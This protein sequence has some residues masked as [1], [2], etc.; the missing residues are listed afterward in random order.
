MTVFL[1]NN[2][3]VFIRPYVE[4]D[5]NKIQDLNKIEGWSNL[6]ENHMNTKEA[7]KNSNVSFVVET[8]TKNVIGYIRG[9]TDTRISLFICELLIDKMYRGFGLGKELIYYVHS[10]YPDKS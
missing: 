4:G 10:L 3:K 8:E 9:F 5:I 6:V 2:T 1:K 7:W